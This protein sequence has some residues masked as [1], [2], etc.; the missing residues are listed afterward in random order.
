M[1][2]RR[3]TTGN[4]VRDLVVVELPP[5]EEKKVGAIS[6]VGDVTK[7]ETCAVAN[8]GEVVAV[9]PDVKTVEVGN[10]VK[11]LSLNAHPV[12]LFDGDVR[13]VVM[14]EDEV[15]YVY[16]NSEIVTAVIVEGK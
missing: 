10:T 4:T 7:D 9:G 3:I 1:E 11:W 13:H 2:D 16:Q 6:V 14:G 8:T 12:V 5:P 15:V